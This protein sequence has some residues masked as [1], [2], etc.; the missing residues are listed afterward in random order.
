[1]VLLVGC[2]AGECNARQQNTVPP[3]TTTMSLIELGY[4][5]AAC[6]T[7]QTILTLSCCAVPSWTYRFYRYAPNVRST[8]VCLVESVL[9]V[10]SAIVLKCFQQKCY[11]FLSELPQGYLSPAT[12]RHVLEELMISLHTWQAPAWLSPCTQLSHNFPHLLCRSDLSSFDSFD[13]ATFNRQRLWLF[14]AY[15]V[16]FGSIIGACVLLIS[17]M[18]HEDAAPY[19]RWVGWVR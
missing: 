8:K 13:A 1:M 7:A 2:S 11:N 6:A 4:R 16:S 19:D 12:T 3:G 10:L 18:S 5:A 17:H 15:V 14:I 9:S